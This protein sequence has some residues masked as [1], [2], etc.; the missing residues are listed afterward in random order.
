MKNLSYKINFAYYNM[1][2]I[3]SIYYFRHKYFE[4]PHSKGTNDIFR[5]SQIS[6]DLLIK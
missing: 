2:R 6:F 1:E 3:S 4:L 5:Y